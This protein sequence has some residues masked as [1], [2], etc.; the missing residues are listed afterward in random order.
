MQDRPTAARS[1]ERFTSAG[2][3]RLRPAGPVR[4]CATSGRA[5]PV[6]VP[7]PPEQAESTPPPR[8]RQASVEALSAIGGRVVL[9]CSGLPTVGL[10]A[11]RGRDG[12]GEGEKEPLRSCAPADKLYAKLALE[13]AEFQVSVDA[14]LLGAG[15]AEV[16][17]LGALCT[18]TGGS[19]YHYAAFSTALDFAQLHNDLR[20]LAARPQGLEAVARLRVSQGLSVVEYEG[21]FCKRTPTD[22]DLPAIDCDKARAHASMWPTSSCTPLWPAHAHP[23]AHMPSALPACL[24]WHSGHTPARVASLAVA[25]RE[26]AAWAALGGRRCW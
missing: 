23:P 11:L 15:A 19:L 13:A 26:R 16:A 20:W 2:G 14:L 6:S 22:V 8:C 10:G 3:P 17:T 18:G 4:L 24:A 1:T 25:L 12:R 5:S 9:F 21:A 7:C